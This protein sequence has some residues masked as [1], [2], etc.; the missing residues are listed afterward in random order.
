MPAGSLAV[1][2]GGLVGRRI[3]VGDVVAIILPLIGNLIIASGG[4]RSAADHAGRIVIAY[5]L[6]AGFNGAGGKVVAHGQ[7]PCAGARYKG[8]LAAAAVLCLAGKGISAGLHT[9]GRGRLVRAGGGV[10]DD[11]GVIL[12]LIGNAPVAAAG[13]RVAVYHAGRSPVVNVFAVGFN[14]AGGEAA[15][16]RYRGGISLGGRT[17]CVSL[18]IQSISHRRPH[19]H[20]HKGRGRLPVQAVT[21]Q[22]VRVRVVSRSRQGG[23]FAVADYAGV[24]GQRQVRRHGMH[25]NGNGR[26]G[27]NRAGAFLAGGL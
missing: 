17:A 1:R 7:Y 4:I 15:V 18:C 9:V 10:G 11:A 8:R 12:P 20:Y 23:A 21:G 27:S 24:G 3:G 6:P 22:A 5:G 13:V 16:P 2:R 14:L 19:R 26:G 25:R